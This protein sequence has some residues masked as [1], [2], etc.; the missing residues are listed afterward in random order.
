MVNT[1]LVV[2]DEP[3]QKGIRITIKYNKL[4]K[5]PVLNYKILYMNTI[6]SYHNMIIEQRNSK[7]NVNAPSK[8]GQKINIRTKGTFSLKKEYM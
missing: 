2:M 4:T 5:K 8:N 3:R 1:Q 7:S 6:I